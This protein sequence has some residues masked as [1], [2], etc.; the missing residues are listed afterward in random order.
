MGIPA[1]SN[2]E[3]TAADNRRIKLALVSCGLGNV[4]RGF[5]VSTSRWFAA[6]NDD[7]QFEV[8]LFSGGDYPNATALR[9]IRRDSILNSPLRILRRLDKQRFWEFS[10]VVEQLSFFT[11]FATELM[12]W[13][14]DVIWTKEVP[15]AH[16]LIVLRRLFNQEFK[17]IFANGGAFRPPTY[18]D[19]DFIQH[20]HPQSY[21]DA[22]NYGIAHQ[23]MQVL[24]NCVEYLMP[25]QSREELRAEFGYRQNDWVVLCVAAWNRYQK[26]LDYLINEVAAMEDPSVK[27]LMCG[28]PETETADLQILAG[29]KLPDRVKWMTLLPH[30]VHKAM[31]LADIFVLP[32]FREGLNNALIEAA[33]AG[34]PII[35]HP[36]PGAKF[37]LQDD[38]WLADLSRIG[39]LTERLLSFKNEPNEH[40]KLLH[41]QQSVH[42]RFSKEELAPRFKEM[43]CRLI[44][45][46]EKE[47]FI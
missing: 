36:H 42:E 23:R 44:N 28:H 6:L 22:A 12:N 27:I 4:Q 24:P 47:C 34:L 1:I 5:E 43:V 17:I 21:E 13:A 40:E 2:S 30:E 14:P 7:P 26:R 16:G 38:L 19:F 3:S 11:S 20:L 29:E 39:T 32:S 35:S 8:R 9:N 33:M 15:F 37:V 18:K 31:K 45:G 25:A 46:A 41:L 10:Y